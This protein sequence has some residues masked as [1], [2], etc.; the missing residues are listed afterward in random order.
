MTDWSYLQQLFGSI[1]HKM[2]EL[3]TMILV[4]SVLSIKPTFS[5]FSFTFIKR[6][7]SSSLSAIRIVSSAYLR[8]LIFLPAILIPACASSS[9]VWQRVMLLNASWQCHIW[10][11]TDW[12]SLYYDKWTDFISFSY[13]TQYDILGDVA[14]N[15][16]ISFL[17][18]EWH[19]SWTIKK[20]ERQRIHGVTESDM[21]ETT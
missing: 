2:M 1:C 18:A 7:F 19:S 13:F 15:G 11:V 3:D 17:M 4:F 5:L 9:P 10:Q 6:L 8:L 12:R 16:L 20:A 14:A 21:T